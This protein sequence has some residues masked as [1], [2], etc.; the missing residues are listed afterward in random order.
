MLFLF[1]LYIICKI[2]YSK[3]NMHI[4]LDLR[5][6]KSWEKY[7]TFI[8]ILMQHLISIDTENNYTFYLSNENKANF[9]D[10][11][12]IEYIK[13]KPWSFFEQ[14]KFFIKLK[15]DKNDIMIFFDE[16][17][18]LWHSWKYILF[19]E[20]LKELH[21]SKQKSSLIKFLED[22]FLKQSLKNAYKIISF[23]NKTKEELNEKLNIDEN[24]L[25]VLYPF[26]TKQNIG[27]DNI[28]TNIKT[29]YSIK[30]EYFIYSWGIW[31]NKN[32]S[33]LI[34]V[35]KKIKQKNINVNLVIL[36]QELTEDI[37]IRKEVVEM[38]IIEKIFFVWNTSLEEKK[39]F[40]NEAIWSIFPSLYES[41][42]FELTES[43]S[44]NSPI[45]SSSIKQIRE[46]MWDEISYFSPVSSI[47]IIEAIENFLEKWKK[48][49]NYDNL[50]IKY[51][52]V[53]SSKHLLKIIQKI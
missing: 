44:Y 35:F 37:Y 24:K 41:F 52:P 39:A 53:N 1:F 3:N 46:I 49:T 38:W 27:K 34:E 21:Y 10:K 42:P 9:S 31:N 19:I 28:I 51:S 14:F 15:K 16:K 33:K 50:F 26:F 47:D 2:I 18:P 25:E 8:A 36:N 22:L 40:Y 17:K 11:I 29:K 13:E 30:W 45:L 5:F 12:K 4:W 48:R 23:E 43:L 6:L 20:D 7:S 32:L